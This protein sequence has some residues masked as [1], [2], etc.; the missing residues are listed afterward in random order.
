VLKLIPKDWATDESEKQAD[1]FAAL[2]HGSSGAR[3]LC[4]PFEKWLQILKF[5]EKYMTMNELPD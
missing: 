2:A 4:T 1:N 5:S 3:R